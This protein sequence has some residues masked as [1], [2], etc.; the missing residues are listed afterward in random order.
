[1]IEWLWP[2]VVVLAPLPWLVRRFLPAAESREPALR[3]PF[4]DE[5]RQLSA[6]EGAASLRS[7]TLPLVGLWLVWLL[8]LAAA[9]RPVWIGEP[10]ELP[11]SGRDLMVAVDISG[12]MRIEDMQV[13]QTLARRIDAVRQLGA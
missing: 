12:S 5:W 1:M 3:A 8:L 6:S 2:W 11:N 9:A 7:G 13:G 4:F 10:V